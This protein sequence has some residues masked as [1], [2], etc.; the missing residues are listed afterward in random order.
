MGSSSLEKC[1]WFRGQTLERQILTVPPPMADVSTV[2]G[3]NT[4]GAPHRKPIMRSEARRKRP[5][6]LR[7]GQTAMRK[8]G[9]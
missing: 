5:R 2:K 6:Y 9:I 8:T 1:P 3:P 7:R 4:K